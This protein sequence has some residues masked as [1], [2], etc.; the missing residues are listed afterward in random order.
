ML[1]GQGGGVEQEKSEKPV[2]N[3]VLIPPHLP[4]LFW[5]ILRNDFDFDFDLDFEWQ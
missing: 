3:C 4:G 5:K 1:G 2:M